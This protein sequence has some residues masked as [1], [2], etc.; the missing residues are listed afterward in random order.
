M[1]A[2]HTPRDLIRPHRTDCSG[3]GNM[4][5][6]ICADSAVIWGRK[7]DSSFLS[8]GSRDPQRLVRGGLRVAPG[9]RGVAR[10]GLV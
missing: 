7:W 6:P 9:C 4:N 3:Q 10:L 5:I 2:N 8:C 1:R